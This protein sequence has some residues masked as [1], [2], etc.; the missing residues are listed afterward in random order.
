MKQFKGILRPEFPAATLPA[1][2]SLNIQARTSPGPCRVYF[3]SAEPRG[4]YI[5]VQ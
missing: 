5:N 1:I 2:G 4:V 3:N